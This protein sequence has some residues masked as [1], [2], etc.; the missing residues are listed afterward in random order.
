M[1]VRKIAVIEDRSTDPRSTEEE[2]SKSLLNQRKE[3]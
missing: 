1:I 2:I 3:R